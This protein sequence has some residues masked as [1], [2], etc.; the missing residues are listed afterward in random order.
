[1]DN[2]RPFF[3][4]RIGVVRD[5]ST[6]QNLQN[7]ICFGARLS[8]KLNNNLRLGLL[9]MQGGKDGRLKLPSTNYSV[10]TLQQKLFSRSNIALI[11]INKQAFQDSIGGNFTVNPELYNRLVG[12]DF[13][14]ASAQ[15]TW[16]GKLF[17]HRSFD[18]TKLDSAFATGVGFTY[19]TLRWSVDYIARAVGANYN[20]EVGFARR[21]DFK[22]TSSTI[23]YAFYPRS[24]TVQR[25][26]PG[27]DFDAVWN[28]QYGF[29]D[30]DLNL[31]YNINFK[32]TSEFGLR[33]RK[34]FTYLF[35]DFDPTGTSGVTLLAGTGYT[36]YM[37][38]VDYLSDQR[39]RLF[40]SLGSRSGE[41]FN[42]T[43]LNLDGT[44]SFRSQ[45]YSVLSMNFSLNRINLPK[46]YTSA[47]L[48][49]VGPKI[50]ITF[51]KKLFWTTFVQY[52]NQI[53]NVNINSRLQ[54]RFRPVSDLFLVYTDNYATESY[55]DN[56]GR[57]FVG[58]QPKLRAIVLKFSYWLNL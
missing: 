21:K 27:F 26:G 42:G 37:I 31:L 22:Q 53:N 47:T 52:N 3:S 28:Q 18:N 36:N 35:S 43:R 51:S 56:D 55:T 46:P 50:D 48:L 45:P 12:A 9:T 30:W 15:S 20:P 13:N 6:G 19:N 4:R 39:R 17:Y 7:R 34:Q 29:L 57:V 2:M 23:K 5:S 44:I 32:N 14:L 58:G 11:M 40:V 41:Y 1:M 33:L 8:G 25:H 24:K 54:W 49:L 16:N 10:L 38:V